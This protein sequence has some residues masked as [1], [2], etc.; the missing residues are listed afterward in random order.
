MR[1]KIFSEKNRE[2]L[3]DSAIFSSFSS[4][5]YLPKIKKRFQKTIL[6]FVIEK[7][8]ALSLFF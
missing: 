2:K 5:V 7:L 4:K 3:K 6:R 1:K 8:K